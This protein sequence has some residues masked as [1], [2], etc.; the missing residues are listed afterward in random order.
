MES[1]DPLDLTLLL[2][3]ILHRAQRWVGTEHGYLCLVNPAV[4]KMEIVYGTGVATPYNDS[5]IERGE[6]LA[7]KVWETEDILVI[8]D[9]GQWSGR[10]SD[11]RT[12]NR[13]TAVAAIGVPIR[14][15]GDTVG[16]IGLFYTEK[17]R[18]FTQEEIQF[19]TRMGDTAGTVLDNASRTRPDQLDT[20]VD[21]FHQAF[22]DP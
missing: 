15:A 6:G 3:A 19:L 7:G 17:E 4:D 9:Y 12:Q 16:V 10:V 13:R 22:P 5:Y 8:P 14:L 11:Q 21:A 1:S 18:Q 20:H 2:A